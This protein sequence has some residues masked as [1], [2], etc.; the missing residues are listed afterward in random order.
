MHVLTRL[1]TILYAVALAIG[2]LPESLIAVLSICFAA[3]ASRMAKSGV[4]VRRLEALEA[5]GGVDVICSDKTGTLTLGK[6]VVREAWLP[7]RDAADGHS[8]GVDHSGPALEPAG[9]V[10]QGETRFD[11]GTY[12]PAMHSL[13]E[14]AALCNVAT[15]AQ[16]DAGTW[17]G[18]G[19]PTELALQVFAHK[20]SLG[21]ASLTE[22]ADAQYTLAQEHPFD[23]ATKRMTSMYRS[24]AEPDVYRLFMKGGLD[25]V[26]ECCTGLRRD[27]ATVPLDDALRA[28]IRAQMRRMASKG[29]RVLA[30]AQRRVGAADIDDAK[31]KKEA[32][33]ELMARTEAECHFDFVALAGLYDPPRPETAGA[34]ATCHTAGISV[35]MVT[36]DEQATA[37]AIA[38]QVG[39]LPD[40]A[41]HSAEHI[42]ALVTNATRF[43]AL[44]D[45]DIDALES[46]PLVIAR[47]TPQTKVRLIKAARRRGMRGAMT[48]DGVN[49]APA[50]KN[51]DI[52]VAMGS[53]T[54]IAKDSSALI[55]TDDCFS[56]I[57][58]GIRQGR[59]VFDSIKKVRRCVARRCACPLLT[60]SPTVPRRAARRQCRRGHPVAHRPRPARQCARPGEHLPDRAARHLVP[61]PS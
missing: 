24:R 15:L 44:T 12:P 14:A 52:G 53:G 46:L 49:D 31:D 28:D 35:I 42:D 22:G 1:Q 41:T 10:F 13:V 11:A 55:I 37:H 48:G 29:L 27:D 40:L 38:L 47:C 33:G 19:D 21:R 57:T 59:C 17:S 23:S 36:G 9:Q 39:I 18:R 43:D 5:L 8:F 51:A 32:R 54:D 50:L 56:S 45:A 30:F 34:V 26:L 60:L 25:R 16:D 4:I 2:V 6:M 3:G 20:C 58:E 61:Q 7:A